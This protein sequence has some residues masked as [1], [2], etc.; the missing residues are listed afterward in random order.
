MG[1]ADDRLVRQGR[2][3]A[4]RNMEVMKAGAAV[5]GQGPKKVAEAMR[6]KYVEQRGGNAT[7]RRGYDYSLGGSAAADREYLKKK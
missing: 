4:K 2:A 5:S 1:S 7:L 6:D 3:I